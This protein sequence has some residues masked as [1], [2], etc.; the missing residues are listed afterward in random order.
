MN[1]TNIW[2]VMVAQPQVNLPRRIFARSHVINRTR[3]LRKEAPTAFC[4]RGFGHKTAI[5]RYYAHMW[6][7]PDVQPPGDVV[8]VEFFVHGLEERKPILHGTSVLFRQL[9]RQPEPCRDAHQQGQH[10]AHA[11]GQM[12]S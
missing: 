8:E 2:Y 9:A 7:L 1:I 10:S 5:K 12:Q 11:H 4:R 6:R 3:F